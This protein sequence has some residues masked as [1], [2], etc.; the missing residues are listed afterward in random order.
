MPDPQLLAEALVLL[1]AQALPTL[2]AAGEKA[3]GKAVEEVGKQAGAAA[4]GKV[5]EIWGRLRGKVEEKEAAKEAVTDLAEEPA[6]PDRQAALRRQLIKILTA[7]PDLAALL[8]PLAETARTE[9]TVI[10]V[11]A[12]DRGV[13]VGRDAYGPIT[14]HNITPAATPPDRTAPA[15]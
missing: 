13:A 2:L 4:S 1:L 8:E 9:V 11:Q 15:A 3:A 14:I 5:K 10:Q 12:G 7:D 6:D